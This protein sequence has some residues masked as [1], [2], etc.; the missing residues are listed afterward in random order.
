VINK[1]RHAARKLRG[2]DLAELRG[3]GAQ[4]LAA[5]RERVGL[6][7]GELRAHPGD[8][9][10]RLA[11]GVPHDPA[12]L[13]AAFRREAPPFFAGL[14]DRAATVAALRAAVPEAEG[15]V[16]RRAD[17][18]LA[19]RFDLLGYRDLSFGD[20][21]DWHRDPVH[22]KRAD[23]THWSRVPYLDPEIVGDH[24]V[25]WEVN[26]Q[27]FLVT[28]GQAYWYTGDERYAEG[29][30]RIVTAWMDANPPKRGINWASS[31]EVAFRA[32]SWVWALRFFRHSPSLTPALF[33]R[34]LGYL[35][36]HARHLETYLSTYFSPNTHLT[37]EAL[38]LVWV[39][40][41]LPQLA[42]APRWA[43]TGETILL[44]QLDR[45]I[46]DDGVYFEQAS[47]YH[48]YTTEFYFQLLLLTERQ[49]RRVDPRL[50]ASVPR[51]LDFLRHLARPDGTMPLFGDDDGGRLVQLDGRTPEDVRALLATGAARFDR[52]DW[53]WVGGDELA[54]AIWLLGPAAVATRPAPAQPAERSRA[55]GTSGFFVLRDGWGADASHLLL[56]CGP[57]GVYNG[58][59]AHADA[60]ALTLTARGRHVLVDAGT[61]T[62]PWADRNA[63]RG[64]RAHNTLLLDGEGSSTPAAGAFQWT[65]AARC[66]PTVWVATPAFDLVAGTHDGFGRL[67]DPAI[68]ERAVLH[69]P[70]RGWVVRDR[71]RAT[72][73]HDVALR[74][75]LAPGLTVRSLGEGTADVLAPS[76]EVLLR[77][78][79]A[80]G[81]GGALAVEPGRVSPQYGAVVEAPV[82]AWRQAGVGAQEVVTF[83]LPP[84]GSGRAPEVQAEPVR[85]TG[86][87][88]AFLAGPTDIHIDEAVWAPELVVVGSGAPVTG[89][90]VE[91]DAEWLWLP[92][93]GDRV[94]M[95]GG[96]YLRVAGDSIVPQAAGR[97]GGDGPGQVSWQVVAR[98]PA[99]WQAVDR[100]PVGPPAGATMDVN[101]MA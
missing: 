83:L 49:G 5:W 32:M 16:I 64:A 69:L 97:G 14:D 20:P 24:K 92:A 9:G 60:L 75:Q 18:A 10:R 40:W 55:F 93:G 15:E 21:I 30:A 85:G 81:A 63:F 62:Y 13:L 59:H 37:G 47:Q 43:R 77:V 67:P 39:G 100:G 45:Q 41:L 94:V 3:R 53:A 22:G 80:G 99:G 68:H 74:W 38:G 7:A 91:T 33:A 19:G 51:L 96:E 87:M 57:H 84:D 52:A 82:L 23:A 46:R 12:E 26:R 8:L 70:G 95:V 61:F 89:A 35:H 11:A 2:R 6:D 48:R 88:F 34:L 56:D 50:A 29:F 79:V 86:R 42:G 25:V 44:T 36:V 65:D 28:L 17:A 31:L 54:P 58:G 71:V 4:A 76:G 101:G 1:I 72:G 73:R 98:T 66:T 27:Q 90:G 78:V